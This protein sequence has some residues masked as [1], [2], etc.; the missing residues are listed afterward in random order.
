M[1]QGRGL[2]GSVL[3]MVVL[4]SACRG[5]AVVDAPVTAPTSAELQAAISP[6]NRTTRSMHHCKKHWI[7]QL[8]LQVTTT[9]RMV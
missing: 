5:A 4:S 9:K 3:A 8:I 6:C 7:R 2:L 1:R